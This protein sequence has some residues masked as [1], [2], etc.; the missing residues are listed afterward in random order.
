MSSNGEKVAIVTGAAQGIGRSIA[1]QLAEDG[2]SVVVSDIASK[3]NLLE[4]V[5]E[6]IKKGGKRALAVAADVSSEKD[7]SALVGKTTDAFGG[8]DVMVANAGVC[9]PNSILEVTVD[10]WERLF[11]VNVRGVLLCYQYAAKA[12]I[13][14]KRGGSIIGAS[15]IAG[16]KGL[17]MTSAYC[18]SKAAI[19]SLT[20]TA[21][22]ELGGHN[23]RVN[24]YAPGA[25][26]TP[27]L[28]EAGRNMYQG[29]GTG[30]DAIVEQFKKATALHRVGQPP[31]IA[32]LVSFLASEKSSYIT[33]Q[34]ITADGGVWYD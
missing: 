33:G 21:A 20:Q 10:E 6:E 13:A 26:V 19:R 30:D 32:G 9:W 15:S 17:P 12:M 28:E 3:Q 5:V 16:K 25:I 11:A 34:T 22:Q 7:V 27:M 8:L 14:Q 2:Y 29:P 18:A 23:I 4:E 24:A 1:T 31:E